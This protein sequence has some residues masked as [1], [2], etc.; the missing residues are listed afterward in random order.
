[1]LEF[2]A[3][4]C[5]PLA[6]PSFSREFCSRFRRTRMDFTGLTLYAA[7]SMFT[8]CHLRNLKYVGV[9][10]CALLCSFLAGFPSRVW[11]RFRRTRMDFAGLTA[12]AVE[13]MVTIWHFRDLKHV[14]FRGCG[15]W[16]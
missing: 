16:S 2:E 1:M 9:R 10:G 3:V 13:D 5:R 8:S 11:S 4:L 7:E 15:L 12:Y 6:L 14:G